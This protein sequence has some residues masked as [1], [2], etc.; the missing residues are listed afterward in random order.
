MNTFNYSPTDAIYSPSKLTPHLHEQ[1]ILN[2]TIYCIS[3]LHGRH[4]QKILQNPLMS[5]MLQSAI[6]HCSF[7]IVGQL[8]LKEHL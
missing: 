5:K 3:K 8:L 1:V 2:K 7:H 4:Q 6:A